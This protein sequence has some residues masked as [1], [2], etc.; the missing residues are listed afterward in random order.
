MKSMFGLLIA[1][2]LT[3]CSA[4]MQLVERGGNGMYSGIV[5]KTSADSGNMSAS[6][7]GQS[8]Q[9]TWTVAANQT[10][11]LAMNGSVSTV[12][13]L[14]STSGSAS[15]IMISP[16]GWKMV[17]KFSYGHMT[18]VGACLLNDARLFDM[19]FQ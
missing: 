12:Y 15:S 1:L 5:T 9:G 18:G 4:P 13:A 17:C 14:N 10:M 19:Q 11:G 8:L 6:I 2:L 7:D 16:S 3:A